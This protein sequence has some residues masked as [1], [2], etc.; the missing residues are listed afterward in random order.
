MSAAASA[1][2]AES[3]HTHLLW[4]PAAWLGGHWVERVLFEVGAD[5][6][7]H[8]I[9]PDVPAPDGVE[10]LDGPVLP[11]LVNAH[12]HAFQRAFVGLAERR[13][14]D[15][16]DFWTWRDRMYQIALRVTPDQLRAIATHLYCELLDGG[17]T[18]VCE[19]HYLH[20]DRDGSRYAEPWAMAS[21]LADAARAAGIG[22]TLL[23]VLYERAGFGQPELRPDQRRFATSVA[24]VLACRDAVCGGQVLPGVAIHSLRA[25]T[26]E[27]L[28]ALADA[29]D[30]PLHI[31]VAE[32]TAEVA[33]CL[34][35]TGLRPV[36]WLARHAPLDA[37]W[38]LVHATHVTSAEVEAVATAGAGVVLCPTTEANLGDGLTDLPGWLAAGTRLSVGTDSHVV[39]NLS[40]ELR[41]LELG[42]RLTRRARNVA[43]APGRQSATAARLFDQ[44]LAGGA[45]A[46]GL[47]RFGFEPGA[48]AD[49]LVLDLDDPAFAGVPTSHLLDALVFAAP[50]RMTARVLVAGAWVTP[51][52]AAIRRRYDDAVAELLETSA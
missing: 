31:H 17:Y 14:G 2:P 25:A 16:D 34:A 24:D 50:A 27:S 39:R 9:E 51:E 3:G 42:Q 18:H 37:R 35:A 13:D 22:L 19:F 20:H 6:R 46:A 44:V 7:W 28:H 33:D 15:T 45:R 10:R 49:L 1:D 40:E 48:R 30:G 29:A 43:A 4:A 26:A 8:H 12:S 32:Q 5:G 36:E 38:E 41:L 21:S 47:E 23:P 52:R 11:P